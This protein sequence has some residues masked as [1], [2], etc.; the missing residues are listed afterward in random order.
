MF[1][2]D[3]SSENNRFVINCGFSKRVTRG[4]L[5]SSDL[6][7]KAVGRGG[8]ER[9]LSE[10]GIKEVAKWV[11]ENNSKGITFG[12]KTFLK[13]THVTIGVLWSNDIDYDSKLLAMMKRSC[14]PQDLLH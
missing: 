4:C 2:G 6:F 7:V 12:F 5:R 11:R 13:N 9:N 1:S 10:E 3:F 8:L 14:I